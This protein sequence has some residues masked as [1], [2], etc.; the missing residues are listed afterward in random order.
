MGHPI[1]T[2]T[3]L[4]RS[5]FGRGQIILQDPISKVF[6]AGSDPRSDGCAMTYV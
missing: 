4:K 5:L 2:I 3:G 6:S 1:Q